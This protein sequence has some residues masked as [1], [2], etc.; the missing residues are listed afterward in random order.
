MFNIFHFLFPID[1]SVKNGALHLL[2]L[3]TFKT[4]ILKLNKKLIGR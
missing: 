2:H 4:P 3:L 1:G